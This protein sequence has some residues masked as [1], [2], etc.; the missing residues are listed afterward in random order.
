MPY[1]VMSASAFGATTAPRRPCSTRPA[2]KRESRIMRALIPVE[3]TSAGVTSILKT[4]NR[5]QGN[6]RFT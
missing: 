1:G 4:W 5:E 3:K 2:V 6:A